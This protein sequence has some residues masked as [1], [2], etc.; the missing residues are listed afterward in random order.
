MCFRCVYDLLANIPTYSSVHEGSVE[1]SL[2][3]VLSNLKRWL[4][5]GGGVTVSL[6]GVFSFFTP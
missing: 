4:W 6:A 5:W 1:V 3:G 2:G